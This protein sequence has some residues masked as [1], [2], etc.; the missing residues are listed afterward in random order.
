[1]GDDQTWEPISEPDLA[2]LVAQA[3]ARM[4]PAFMAF[5]ESIWE[6]IP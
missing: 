6:F 5:W 2:A 3:E 4:E 1:M